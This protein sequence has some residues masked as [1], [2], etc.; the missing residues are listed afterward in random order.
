MIWGGG[1]EQSVFVCVERVCVC[2]C[3]PVDSPGCLLLLSS[4]FRV[5]EHNSPPADFL[6]LSQPF[7][8]PDN[9][10]GGHGGVNALRSWNPITFAEARE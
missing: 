9:A 4:S 5:L 3:M 7:R 10:G 8:C 2:V 1:V 6:S